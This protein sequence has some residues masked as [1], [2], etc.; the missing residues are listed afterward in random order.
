M[1]GRFARGVIWNIASLAV[2][3]ACGLGLNAII[4]AFYGPAV[5]GS[6][7]QAYAVYILASQIG[8]LGVNFSTN[9]YVAEYAD[10]SQELASIVSAALIVALGCSIPI[11]TSLYYGRHAVGVFLDSPETAIA[12]G[13][14]APAV[15]CLSIN[16]VL[17]HVINGLRRMGLFAVVTGGRYVGIFLSM[18][19]L[20]FFNVSGSSLAFA[21]LIGE[22]AA[23]I[24]LLVIVVRIVPLT[25]CNLRFWVKRHFSFGARVFMSGTLGELNTRL[26]VLILGAFVSDQL[27]GIYSLAAMLAEGYHLLANGLAVNLN[28]IIT[29]RYTQ[30]KLDSLKSMILRGKCYFY[31]ASLLVVGVAVLLFRPLLGVVIDLANYPGAYWVFSIH[32][33]GILVVSGYMPFR[34]ALVQMGFPG[35]YTLQMLSGVLSNVL[36]NLMLIPFWGIYGAAL[37]TVIAYAVSVLFQRFLVLR[38]V[39]I[40]I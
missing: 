15:I 17:V 35:L 26:D 10:N 38:S 22:G 2:M 21:F 40:R 23:L 9:K 7:N 31:L 8:V 3:A 27:V 37:A 12:I 13:Y 4:A 20:C 32:S 19:A 24:C 39:G 14:V 16:K 36:L 1:S 28:P 25:V 30:N 11:G 29:Q 6:F 34:K 5:L 33:C 18:L